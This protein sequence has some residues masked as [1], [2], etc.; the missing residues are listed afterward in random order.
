[1]QIKAVAFI[2]G[3]RFAAQSSESIAEYGKI[4]HW[5]G[6]VKNERSHWGVMAADAVAHA[7]EV[8]SGRAELD[9]KP[10]ISKRLKS[11]TALSPQIARTQKHSTFL[12]RFYVF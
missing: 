10:S 2:F 7:V 5:L 12:T 8:R 1:M 6:S 11:S 4:P 3:P 9:V